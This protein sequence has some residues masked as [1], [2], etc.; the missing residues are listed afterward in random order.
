[1]TKYLDQTIEPLGEEQIFEH[2]NGANGVPQS[3]REP[4]IQCKFDLLEFLHY[5]RHQ[6]L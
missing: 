1:M 2:N 3:S 4:S 6:L 5:M